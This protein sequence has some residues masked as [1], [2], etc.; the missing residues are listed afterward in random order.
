MPTV[1]ANGINL[2][3]ERFGESGDPVLLMVNGLGSQCIRYDDELCEAFV[4]RY[5]Q[6]IRFDNRDVG[7]STHLTEGAS[8]ALTDM[9]ADAVGL[10]D[11]LA[12][13]RAHVWGCSM[14]GMISQLLAI[15]HPQR[16]ASLTSIMSTTGERDVGRASPEIVAS[17]IELS[18][19]TDDLDLAVDRA[20]AHAQVIGSPDEW[21][22]E[23]QRRRQRA[24][25]ERAY[26]PGGVARQ[27]AAV[28]A[29]PDRA[30]GLARIDVPTLVIHGDADP[31]VDVSGGRRT[32]ELVPNAELL[33][34]EG[35][36]HDLP[37]AF[38]APIVEATTQLVISTL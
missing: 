14:G 24:F 13:Q 4:D 12:I 23:W 7:L 19:P 2:Y 8:Y 36:G 9:A 1:A 31:L 20:V 37:P 30:D 3:C 17:L 35:M 10:L 15:E 11:A 38:W 16:V 33:V 25:V 29:S 22:E 27:A 6:V 28:M 26:D 32:A 5:L 34:L 18:A 21:D